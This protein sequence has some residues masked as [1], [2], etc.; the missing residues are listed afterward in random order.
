MFFLWVYHMLPCPHIVA[1]MEMCHWDLLQEKLLQ[2]ADWQSQ[3]PPLDPPLHWEQSSP[4]C[5]QS[6]TSIAG[7]AIEDHSYSTLSTRQFLLGDSALAWWRFSQNCTTVWGFLPH[8]SS[9]IPCAS[10]EPALADY[11]S[12][13]H[14]CF[15]Q[16]ISWYLLLRTETDTICQPKF[17]RLPGQ[18]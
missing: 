13:L 4:G 6:V 1:A 12:I 9:L 8:S 15:S 10:I 3:L 7:G 16:Y 2:E 17:N 14:R 5:T 18:L 11:P